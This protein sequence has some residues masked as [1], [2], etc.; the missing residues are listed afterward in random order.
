MLLTLSLLLV[1]FT[2]V[3]H[4]RRFAHKISIQ[5]QIYIKARQPY[6][7]LKTGSN[8]DTIVTPRYAPLPTIQ[9][10]TEFASIQTYIQKTSHIS[11][12]FIF[13]F[14]LFSNGYEFFSCL[15]LTLL[16]LLQVSKEK[17]KK[18]K[19]YNL[20]KMT[21]DVSFL[22]WIDDYSFLFNFSI[23]LVVNFWFNYTSCGT[24]S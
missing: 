17:K 18:N 13:C 20:N 14:I 9:W 11:T 21:N 22:I 1:M 12:H 3:P 23:A 10:N 15:C 4:R 2:A 24:G 5:N 16:L 19:E 7:I 8:W 6:R